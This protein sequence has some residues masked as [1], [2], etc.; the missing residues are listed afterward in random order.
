MFEAVNE[1][2][3]PAIRSPGKIRHMRLGIFL[4]LISLMG[5]CA[6]S[7]KP[8][9][10]SAERVTSGKDGKWY[11]DGKP[12]SGKHINKF[13]NDKVSFEGELVEGRPHGEWIWYFES[14]NKKSELNYALGL[15]DGNETHFY[16]NANNSRMWIK[17]WKRGA[18][19]ESYQWQENGAPI[20]SRT[21]HDNSKTPPA[22]P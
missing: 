11:L 19:V 14:G 2:G 5:L 21:Q 8:E 3:L 12:W 20:I 7:K 16:D 22:V 18:F 6:C 1:V 13:A 4:L 15:K 10:V 9:G 17:T